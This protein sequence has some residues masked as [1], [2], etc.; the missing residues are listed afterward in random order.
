MLARTA[1][2]WIL[3]RLQ[4]VGAGK[5]WAAHGRKGRGVHMQVENIELADESF[6][7]LA[8]SCIS[9]HERGFYAV[10]RQ[11][12]WLTE[13]TTRKRDYNK[14]GLPVSQRKSSHPVSP[15]FICPLPV[16]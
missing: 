6:A 16:V 5:G 3:A 1:V 11:G 13:E 12:L 4:I 10:N 15:F 8:A 14:T 9:A 7:L 2:S